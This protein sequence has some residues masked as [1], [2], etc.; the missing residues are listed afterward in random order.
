MTAG[1][2]LGV[3]SIFN[4]LGRLAWG[5][6][7]DRWGRQTALLGMCGVSVVAC[8]AVLRTAEGFSLLLLGM[9]LV[10]WSY[11]GYLALMPALTADFFGANMSVRI[12]ACCS[13]H[14]EFAAFSFRVTLP[15]CSTPRAR[16]AI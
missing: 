8:A 5:G 3:M 11:G 15:E 6:V 1:A 7:S 4:G 2:G 12:T 10:A 9:C 14:G 16:Q 13:A